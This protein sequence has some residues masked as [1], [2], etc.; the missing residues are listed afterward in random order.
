MFQNRV[1]DFLRSMQLYCDLELLEE[2]SKTRPLLDV[3]TNVLT[4]KNLDSVASVL[5]TF[6][7]TN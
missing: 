4:R 3:S 2:F 1:N 6:W 5:C 7:K